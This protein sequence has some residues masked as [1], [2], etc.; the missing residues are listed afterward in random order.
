MGAIDNRRSLVNLDNLCDLIAT[1]VH[2][3]AAPGNAFLVSDGLDV[4]TPELIQAMGRAFG[5]SARLI[6]IPLT[7]LR[8]AGRLSG[9]QAQ[10]E[11]L[12]DSLQVDI[13]H[14]RGVLGWTPRTSL[15]Q[16]LQRLVQADLK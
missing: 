7:W 8:L 1:C 4:S 6:P 9:R 2:H 12:T 3:P 15:Q 5:R 10:I 16:A 11:R 14:T 13:G